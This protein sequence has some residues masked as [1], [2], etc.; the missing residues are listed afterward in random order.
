MTN[1]IIVLQGHPSLTFSRCG[2]LTI[3]A[4]LKVFW[5]ILVYTLSFRTWTRFWMIL[6]FWRFTHKANQ[7]EA[8]FRDQLI[9]LL[10]LIC[11]RVI[12][13]LLLNVLLL[14]WARY[15][16]YRSVK[17]FNPFIIRFLSLFSIR[18]LNRDVW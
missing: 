18:T 17:T 8:S 9:I 10:R 4:I 15:F 13:W 5:L 1:L 7:I 3:F 11:V 2:G 6:F 12:I 14:F 16:F